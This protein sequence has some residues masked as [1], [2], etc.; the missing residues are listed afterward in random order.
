[1]L[2]RAL[3]AAGATILGWELDLRWALE[4]RRRLGAAALDIVVGDALELPW[5]RVPRGHLVT[6]N[7]PYNVATPILDAVLDQG[8]R[9]PR[10]GFLVQLEVARRLAADVGDADYGA[11]SILT[12]ARARCVL[13]GRVRPGSFH[14]P[15]KVESA[16]VGLEPL[17]TP[18]ADYAALRELVHAAFGRRRKTLRNS[19]DGWRPRK[20]VEAVLEEVGLPATTRAEELSLE[21][22][23]ALLSASANV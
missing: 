5:G 7:L 20:V 12:R 4:L 3:V 10:S 11:L 21:A 23:Q 22:F 6:G 16:F 1:M 14:P 13:L 15:P 17:A 18:A 2:T 9:F 19:L 8:K